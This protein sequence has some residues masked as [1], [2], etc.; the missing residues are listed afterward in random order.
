MYG[1]KSK[2]ISAETLH[3]VE[4]VW[5]GFYNQ[6]DVEIRIYESDEA[7]MNSSTG[8]GAGFLLLE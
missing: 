1:K 8:E 7:G 6:R 5:Y 4:S 3:D 2:E